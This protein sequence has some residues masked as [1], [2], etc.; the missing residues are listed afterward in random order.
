MEEGIIL[1]NKEISHTIG[2]LTKYVKQEIIN[3]YCKIN[4]KNKNIK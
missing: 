4:L 2:Q 3:Q 1:V